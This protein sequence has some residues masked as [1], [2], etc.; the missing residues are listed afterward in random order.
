MVPNGLCG[1][2]WRANSLHTARTLRV[3]SVVWFRSLRS[4]YAHALSTEKGGVEIEIRQ[5]VRIPAFFDSNAPCENCSMLLLYGNIPSYEPQA[6]QRDKQPCFYCNACYNLFCLNCNL[7]SQNTKTSLY[8]LVPPPHITRRLSGNTEANRRTNC[9][10]KSS[11]ILSPNMSEA[12]AITKDQRNWYKR[13][14][15]YE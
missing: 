9:L 3:A 4:Q 6:E 5:F 8:S 14:N 1:M 13:S 10:L 11:D 7:Y 2:K 15:Q 12:A